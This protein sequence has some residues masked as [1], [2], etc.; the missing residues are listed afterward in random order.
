MIYLVIVKEKQKRNVISTSIRVVLYLLL[1]IT[2]LFLVIQIPPVQNFIVGKVVDS[3]LDKSQGAV[4]IEGAHIDFFQGISLDGIHLKSPENEVL[5]SVEKAQISLR[6]SILSVVNGEIDLSD[7]AVE[8]VHINS[9]RYIGETESNL[10]RFI[11]GFSSTT[12][13]SEEPKTQIDLSQLGLYRVYL[14]FYDEVE[15]MMVYGNFDALEIDIGR[16]P[17]NGQDLSLDRLILTYPK[18]QVIHCGPAVTIDSTQIDDNVVADDNDATIPIF[19]IGALEIIDGELDIIDDNGE[20][21]QVDRYNNIDFIASDIDLKSLNDWTMSIGDLSIE[22]PDINLHHFSIK[23]AKRFNNNLELG[24]ILVRTDHSFLRMDAYVSGLSDK[25]EFSKAVIDLSVDNSFTRLEDLFPI[26]PGLQTTFEQDEIVSKPIQVDGEFTFAQ[27]GLAARGLNLWVNGRHHF[28]GN[29][30]V[31]N[32]KE[33][34][35]S[36]IDLDVDQL[37]SDMGDLNYLLT[38]VQIP[39][40]I[41]R[42]G[43]IDF[44]GSFDGLLSHFKARGN[45]LT[46]IGGVFMDV[47]ISESE[48]SIEEIAYDGFLQLDSFDLARLFD[49]E[50]FGSIS[51][52]III[53]NGQGP[54][55]IN[56]NA[57]LYATIDEFSYKDFT[58]RDAIYNGDLSKRVV[59]GRFTISD[60]NLNFVFDGLIDFSAEVPVFEFTVD[61]N[62]IDFCKLNLTQFPCSLSFTSDFNFSGKN[63][64]SAIGQGDLGS[65]VLQHDSSQLVIDNLSIRSNQVGEGMSFSLN[66]D[67]LDAEFTGD[68]NL[69]KVYQIM[70]DQLIK[71]HSGHAQV[72]KI[73]ESQEDLGDQNFDYKLHLK[74]AGPMLSFLGVDLGLT[75]DISITG[76]YKKE[77]GQVVMDIRSPQLKFQ[78]IE[79]QDVNIHLSSGNDIGVFDARIDRIDRNNIQVNNFAI[80]T[81]IVKDSIEWKASYLGDDFNRAFIH[82]KSIL[83]EN[84]YFTTLLQDDIVIDSVTWQVEDNRGFGLYRDKLD[85]ESLVIS[86]MVRSISVTDIN[87]KGIEINLDEFDFQ[88]IN[89]IIDYDKLYFTGFVNGRIQLQDIFT[90]RSISG[91]VDVPD[92]EING[93]NYGD[94]KLIAQQA[95]DGR[96]DL[97]LSIL[98]D[99]Q[100]LLSHGFLDLNKNFVDVDLTLEKYP[101]AFL[102]YIIDDGISETQGTADVKVK[103]EGPLNDMKMSGLGTVQNGGTKIDYLGAFYRLEDQKVVISESFMDLTGV[104]LKD[105]LGNEAVIDGGLRHNMLG[106]FRTDLRI[107]SP[108][109]IGL[110]TTK[111][112][113]PVYYGLGH[114]ALDV[115]FNGPFDAIDIRVKA[116]TGKF[117]Q[118]AV[119]ILTTQYGFDESF[120]VFQSERNG[121]DSLLT[122]T[123]AERLKE[124]GVDF[125][126]TLT[127]TP[128]AEV[129]VIYDEVTS[130]VLVGR[131]RGDLSVKVKRNGD[132]TVYGQYDVEEGQYL[133]TAYGFIAKP[134]TIRNGGTVTWT[135]DPINANL[136]ITADYPNLRAPLNVFLREYIDASSLDASEFSTRQE[137]DLNLLLSGTLFNPDINFDIAFPDLTGELRTLANSKVRTL[138]TTENGI[139]NQVVGLLFFR[140]FLPDNNP[141]ASLDQSTLGQT[142]NNTITEFL[143]SQLSLL[144]SDYLSEKLKG[145]VVTGIDLEIA[146]AQNTSLISD[147]GQDLLSGFVDF[148]PDEV[149]LNSRYRFKNDNFILN[150]GGNFVRENNLGSAQNYLTGDFSLDWFLTENRRLKLRFYGN[151][152]YDEAFAERKQRYGFGL[153]YRREFGSITER[154]FQNLIDELAKDVNNSTTSKSN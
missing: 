36:V 140:N 145:D 26:I 50:E 11:A 31:S 37:K 45:L 139:N 87:Q 34:K 77:F 92:L 85:I 105:E 101:M 129:Q 39:A 28:A 46:G 58:Y 142:G 135:G 127:F 12:S 91:Y 40:E 134:F 126:M 90:E 95:T 141:I 114:G 118:L 72:A 94:L 83:D 136:R 144:F 149:Q 19:S 8:G 3:V 38:S 23:K 82:A 24:E 20:N 110:N 75:G 104:I 109:F 7:F 108:Q 67:Y 106:D 137:V 61:A 18:V 130:N 59:D 133:Y 13:Q 154:D 115:E 5:I 120:I 97:N 150:V 1:F 73:E 41:V 116:T 17:A 152:D 100:N 121:Q 42:M 132:F 27:N 128:E 98:K 68:F 22:S 93:D 55:I 80:N 112:D 74:S 125:E 81:N 21:Y 151:Y 124:S 65:I 89:P 6:S 35:S 43:E 117:S 54:D 123:L 25:Y 4:S 71:N 32:I 57:S 52:A 148:V 64:K 122:E 15:G 69:L 111:L 147:A 84:G 76:S 70:L 47:E 63:F 56:S 86:D 60:N 51:A 62:T 66:S 33:I 9:R 113:N 131:G 53:S 30:S 146:V 16:L 153:N 44:T 88:F 79:A 49:N 2:G 14:D 143:T 102:E 103:I 10:E 29:A 96:V 78:D 107:E 138:K 99:T 48:E 119:P